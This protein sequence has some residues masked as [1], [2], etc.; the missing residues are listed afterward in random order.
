MPRLRSIVLLLVAL[1]A[2]VLAASAQSKD[3]LERFQG[4]LKRLQEG[5]SE[6]SGADFHELKLLVADLRLLWAVD[7]SRQRQIACALLDLTGLTLAGWDPAGTEDAT[8]PEAVL[9]EQCADALRAHLDADLERFL[10]REVLPASATQPIQRRRAALWLVAPRPNP[11]LL[12]ALLTCVRDPDA[13]MRD[14]ALEAVCGYQDPGVHRLFLG[15]LD[16]RPAKPELPR[17][18]ELAERHF[19]RVQLDHG[20]PLV[21][22]LCAIVLPGLASTDWRSVSRAVVLSHPLEHARAVP[23]LI[24]ALESWKKR[25]D[26]GLQAL[27]IEHEIA[28]ALAARAE[29]DYGFDVPRWREWWS[30]V[31]R[32]E[33]APPRTEGGGEAGT[34]PSFFTLRPW[35]DRVVFVLDR[36]G[37]M[38]EPFGPASADGGRRT[39]WDEAV[40]QLCEFVRQLGPSARFNVVV[41][42]DY[43]E[44][45]KEELVPADAAGLRS[46]RLWLDQKPHGGTLLRAGVE[47]ALG[48]RGD[49]GPDLARLEADTVIVLCDGATHEGPEWVRSFLSRVNAS[50]RVAFDGVQIGSEGDGTLERLAQGSG[51]EFVKIEK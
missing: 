34:R 45:W 36:S 19:A 48:V 51:G 18:A 1:F 4:F 26:D 42:H 29:R 2:P 16:G 38:Y 43:A 50:A 15:L 32:G 31:Q 35:T 5:R 49:A 40:A 25:G 8:T 28:R 13:R 3:P 39:R 44:A 30:A 46:V 27:R 37:S 33:L 20:D 10:A 22:R 17:A 7:S 41:F 11:G 9:R 21:E 12:L 23:A 14:L 47:R 24:D 6:T